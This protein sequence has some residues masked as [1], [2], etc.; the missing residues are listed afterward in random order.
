M[1]HQNYWNGATTWQNIYDSA[2][3]RLSKTGILV[4]TSYFDQEHLQA[5]QA[6]QQLGASLVTTIQNP[7]SRP[8][9]DAPNKSVDRHIAIFTKQKD[10][11]I[12]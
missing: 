9:R 8:V 5:L 2:L 6:I 12:V 10:D 3:H 7:Q 1:R 11:L 4:I